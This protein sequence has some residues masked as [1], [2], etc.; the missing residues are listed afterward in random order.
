MIPLRKIEFKQIS[1]EADLDRER[2]AYA[3]VLGKDPWYAVFHWALWRVVTAHVLTPAGLW[4]VTTTV[5]AY[6][7]TLR[8]LEQAEKMPE[9]LIFVI[10]GFGLHCV[11][12]WLW[13]CA[14]VEAKAILMAGAARLRGET[15]TPT[16]GAQ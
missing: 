2:M 7:I 16:E 10:W 5:L 1:T 11:L 3:P 9:K 15:K 12:A 8:A 14:R 6:L 13:L 4:V